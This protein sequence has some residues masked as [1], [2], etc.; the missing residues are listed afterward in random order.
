ML[1]KHL[2]KHWSI[3]LNFVFAF[4][5]A[6]LIYPTEEAPSVDLSGFTQSNVASS[7]QVKID[8]SSESVFKIMGQPVV[9]EIR[10][11]I[12]IFHYCKTGEAFDEYVTIETSEDKV[13]LMSYSVAGMDDV[14]FSYTPTPSID[15]LETIKPWDCKHGLKWRILPQNN[16]R[17]FETVP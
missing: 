14:A 2:K 5:L 7:N 6:F 17:A 12:E 10:G 11:G 16:Y 1:L 13:R 3:A 15:F 4:I 8:M 9:K